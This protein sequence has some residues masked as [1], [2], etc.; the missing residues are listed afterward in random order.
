ML[1]E[2]ITQADLGDTVKL[3]VSGEGFEG[4]EIN[5]TIYRDVPFWFNKKIAQT[6]S[7]GWTTWRANETGTYYFKA[8][9]ADGSAEEY[10]SR[11][12]QDY[13][14]LEVTAPEDNYPPYAE[15][16][17]PRNGEIYLVGQEINFTQNSYDE[18]DPLIYSWDFGDG[19]ASSEYNT[20]H[21]YTDTGQMNIMLEVEEETRGQKA[22]D[23]V[24]ILIINLSEEG[25]YVF[26][27]IDEPEWN[28]WY[29]IPMKFNAT[30]S[31]AINVS[32]GQI[33]C[34]AG[35]CPSQTA[36][37]TPIINS[38]Q[39]L[40]NLYFEWFFDD[41]SN[42]TGYGENGATFDNK[43]YTMGGW[44]VVDLRVRLG[45]DVGATY[46]EFYVYLG[47]T[48]CVNE[49]EVSYWL[50]E[51]GD[52]EYSLIDSFEDCF[53][54]ELDETCC[55]IGVFG[56]GTYVCN[57][58]TDK[59]EIS[60]LDSC[61]DYKTEEECEDYDPNVAI[62]DIVSKTGIDNF[63]GGYS[64]YNETTG[65][66]EY[67]QNCRCYWDDSLDSCEPAW[68]W[69]RSCGDGYEE[70]LG[71]CTYTVTEETDCSNGVRLV[72]WLAQWTGEEGDRPL[73]CEDGESIVPC[74]SQ[75]LLGFFSPLNIIIVVLVIIVV[76]LLRRKFG[77]GRKK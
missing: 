40:D 49:E 7:L 45:N 5:F 2:G 70:E 57:K 4:K 15:I 31:Y 47:H 19:T 13:G 22:N 69:A 21:I 61:S 39:P 62:L 51:I 14:I 46:Q 63:C 75:A 17:N 3:V 42:Y 48:S 28:K 18:D 30:S 35:N 20:T 25:I 56:E 38:P 23:K 10:D 32:N 77:R 8:Q 50:E 72:R 41:S 66:Q 55:P 6:S 54:E 58:Q 11:D 26:A 33:E 59:C 36:D 71:N 76:Y 37:G 64:V 24:S 43:I 73:T 65:C 9:P 74:L 34:I 67:P 29:E 12:N 60:F 44:H 68:S 52:M 16:T 1:N 53:N 27:N